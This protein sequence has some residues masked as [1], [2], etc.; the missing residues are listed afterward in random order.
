MTLDEL[1]STDESKWILFTFQKFYEGMKLR[2]A[3]EKQDFTVQ[4]KYIQDCF[5]YHS[6]I[7]DTCSQLE[8]ISIYMRRFDKK[9]FSSNGIGQA[10]FIQ[11]HLEVYVN[12]LYTLSELLLLYTNSIYGLEIKTSQCSFQKIKNNLDNDLQSVKILEMF[13]KNLKNWRLIRNKTVHENKF[14]KDQSFERLAT[15]E[16]LWRQYEILDYEPEIDWR[17][18]KPRHFVDWFLKQERKNK[19]EFIKKNNQGTNK[20]VNMFDKS[21][22]DEIKIKMAM[23]NKE[24]R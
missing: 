18:I 8:Q 9:Y 13:F 10:D 21:T 3:F 12:K 17:I 4:E 2:N 1:N 15:E 20:Y 5:N 22:I 11:Y 16:M 14:S 24:L 23:H 6:Q 7:L 19:I